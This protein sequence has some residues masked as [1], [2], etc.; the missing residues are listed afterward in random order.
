MTAYDQMAEACAAV[1]ALA[2]A[3]GDART[4]AEGHYY[5][6]LA[7]GMRSDPQALGWYEEAEKLFADQ[8]RPIWQARIDNKWANLAVQQGRYAEAETRISRALG[9]SEQLGDAPL[10]ARLLAL[11]GTILSY[12]GEND[13]SLAIQEQALA[14]FQELDDKVSQTM[15][16]NN[17]GQVYSMSGLLV[18]ARRFYEQALALAQVTGDKQ[19]LANILSNFGLLAHEVGDWTKAEALLRQC[20]TLT[21]QIGNKYGECI[22]LLNFGNLAIDQKDAATARTMYV[23]SLR[24]SQAMGNQNNLFFSLNGL[25]A[26]AVLAQDLPRAARLAASA[27]T[28]RLSL[29]TAWDVIEGRIYEATLTAARAGL[30]E[31]AFQSAW[32]EGGRWSLEEA[33]AKALTVA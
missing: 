23:A 8:N 7:W 27:E 22:A 16:L 15:L 17:I 1:L 4:L 6:G 11:R 29:G 5:V 14:I 12:R 30:G 18:E 25:A 28:L 24:I 32:E 2:Q 13:A 10:K 26:T 19:R 21:R 20:L 3:Q 31:A 9:I 33:V